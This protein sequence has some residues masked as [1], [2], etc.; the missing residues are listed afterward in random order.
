[1]QYTS[2]IIINK[3]L[4]FVI[5]KMN[6]PNN[7]KH[8][9]DGL[10]ANEYISGSPGQFGAKMKLH[11]NFGKR[12]M[13]LIE[14][15]TKQNLPDEFHATYTTKGVRNIQENYFVNFKG[16]STKWICKNAFEPTSLKMNAMLFFMPKAFKK[17]T[18]M[19][20]ANFKNFAENNS[21]VSNA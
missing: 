13:E 10:V 21:T 18:K 8:W 11:Y 3:P 20:M 15:I 9:Q 19:Y 7:M 4:D 14:T 2:E 1:M 6:N 17:Q 5:K 16:H 12:K